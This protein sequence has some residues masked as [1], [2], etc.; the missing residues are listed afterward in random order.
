MTESREPSDPAAEPRPQSANPQRRPTLFGVDVIK[1]VFALEYALQG[2]VNPFQGVTYQPFFHHL[3]SDFGLSEG[4][5]QNLFAK[6]Y[7]AWSFKPVLGFLIDAYGRTRTLLIGLLA[8]AAMGYLLTPLLDRGPTLFF[9]S[10]FILSIALA[11]TDVSVDRATVIS[12]EEESKETGR[13]KSTTVGLNQ[14]ICW[15][16]IYGTGTAAAVI[17]GYVADHVPF[18]AFMLS[19]AVVPALVLLVVLRMPRDVEPPIPLARSIGEFWRGLNTGPILGVMFF[20]FVFNFQPMMGA[21]W[22]DHLMGNLHFT[23]TELGLSDGTNNAGYF[24]GVLAFAW[25]GVHWQ[26]RYG[27]K[28]LFRWY[29]LL[30]VAINATQY[31]LVDPWF[32]DVIGGLNPFFPFWT[33]GTLRV[34]YLCAYNFVQGFAFS[35]LRMSVFSLVGAVTPVAAAGSLFAG[36]MSVQNLAMAFSYSSGSWLYE[37]G[38]RFELLRSLEHS[39][40]GG[41]VA[42]GEH[43]SVSMVL[44]INSLAFVLSFAC[45]HVLPDQRETAAREGELPEHPGPERWAI[46]PR[47]LFR[48]VGW[49]ALALG[50]ALFA[51]CFWSWDQ[52][53]ISATVV[54]FFLAV[55][56]RKL[57]LDHLLRR[58]AIK[59]MAI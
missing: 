27:L 6:S 49:S 39:V 14:A 13:S 4:Q 45:V 2:L 25:K 44:L 51:V 52:D 7:L 58:S 29:I 15:T 43:L 53:F 56:L 38:S 46:L 35:L 31:L 9:T 36:F 17:G 19:L 11:A 54:S 55:A 41:V 22:N 34:V 8:L 18:T 28:N 20:S 23:Q 42:E 30:S 12:G 59:S 48:G 37:N 5:T 24:I 16:A 33:T 21:L 47:G 3:R 1:W 50:A 57:A 40:F 32:T 26:D 10:M